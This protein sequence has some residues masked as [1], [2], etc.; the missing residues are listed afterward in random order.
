VDLGRLFFYGHFISSQDILVA[1][2]ITINLFG[3]D[4][5]CYKKLNKTGIKVL[6]EGHFYS[7]LSQP[8][9]QK[10]ELFV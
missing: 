10:A 7:A 9:Y 3:F 5:R 8:T 4:I 2:E 1:L 6:A